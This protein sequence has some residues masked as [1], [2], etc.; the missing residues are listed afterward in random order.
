MRS[1]QGVGNAHLENAMA[2]IRG[3]PWPASANTLAN[4]LDAPMDNGLWLEDL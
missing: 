3:D 2:N 4:Q 1:P